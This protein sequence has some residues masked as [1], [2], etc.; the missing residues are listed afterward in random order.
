M[1]PAW[2]KVIGLPSEYKAIMAS[3]AASCSLRNN[4]RAGKKTGKAKEQKHLLRKV[5]STYS[6]KCI[7]VSA[8][9]N[10]AR[11]TAKELGGKERKEGEKE[12]WDN[13]L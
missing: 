7:A 10:V 12:K 8:T 4:W 13:V 11:T 5:R 9:L 1:T 3:H 6:Y 2:F